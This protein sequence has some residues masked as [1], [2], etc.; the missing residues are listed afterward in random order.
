MSVMRFQFASWRSPNHLLIISWRNVI[1]QDTQYPLLI[2][3]NTHDLFKHE[4]GRS[5]MII[6]QFGRQKI[7]LIIGFFR[8][9]GKKTNLVV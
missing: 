2:H 1:N 9:L 6:N 5:N 7:Q 3:K 8:K 4:I